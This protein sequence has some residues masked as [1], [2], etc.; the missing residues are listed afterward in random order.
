MRIAEE[1]FE[2]ENLSPSFSSLLLL[3]SSILPSFFPHSLPPI[4][5]S[6][7]PSYLPPTHLSIGL[8]IYAFIYMYTNSHSICPPN[9]HPF[10]LSVNSLLEICL[11]ILSAWICVPLSFSLFPSTH[12]SIHL[13]V[14]QP[15]LC[16][17]IHSCMHQ[18]IQCILIHPSHIH[19][20]LNLST[21]PFTGPF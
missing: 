17:P 15:R 18:T 12:T 4:A 21:Q 8:S 7:H 9:M 16:I 11:C 20:S 2:R 1:I 10:I 5:L 6:I 13:C 3:F 14:Y 19:V